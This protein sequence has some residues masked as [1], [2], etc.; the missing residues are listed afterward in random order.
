MSPAVAG[1]VS[2][3]LSL[4]LFVQFTIWLGWPRHED[5]TP[6]GIDCP[7][8]GREQP[9]TGLVRHM[10]TRGRCAG[11]SISYRELSTQRRRW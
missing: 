5:G 3:L 11:R 1:W 8:C 10:L 6:E 4:P 2:G 7:F 9:A